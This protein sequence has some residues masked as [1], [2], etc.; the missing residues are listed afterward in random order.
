MM[1][2]MR[3]AIGMVVR[4]ERKERGWSLKELGAVLDIS[5]PTVGHIEGGR[6]SIGIERLVRIA[7][8]F[9]MTASELVAKAERLQVEDAEQHR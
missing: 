6:H 9:G 7:S 2:E 4:A 5:T 1:L 3:D 8:A